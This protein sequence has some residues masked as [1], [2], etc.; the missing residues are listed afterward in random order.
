MKKKT[1]KL[2]PEERELVAR[3]RKEQAKYKSKKSRKAWEDV[4]QTTHRGYDVSRYWMH[5]TGNT[6][7]FIGGILVI[8]GI[9]FTWLAWTETIWRIAWGAIILGALFAL[10]GLVY[11]RI[12]LGEW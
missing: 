8:L 4:I 1:R 3:L 6:L 7:L 9:I 12:K 11:R 2:Y 10:G 5:S